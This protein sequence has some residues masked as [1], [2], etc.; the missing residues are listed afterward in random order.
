MK[1]TQKLHLAVFGCGF[2]AQYQTAAWQELSDQIEIIALCDR[3]LSRARSL[4]GKLGIGHYYDSPEKLLQD[5]SPHI[6]DIITDV[7]S[8]PSLAKLAADHGAHV[9]CQKPMAASLEKA[10]EMTRYLKGKKVKFYVHENFR[11]QAPIRLLKTYLQEGL[12]G[13]PFK[14]NIKFC[15]SF[16]VFENQPFLAELDQFIL[17][18]VGTHILDVTRFLFGEA[19]SLFCQTQRINPKIQGEDVANVFMRM[20]NAVDCYA[21][22]SYATIWEHERF[23]ETYIMI[24]GSKGSLYL[25]PKFTISITTDEGTRT[26]VVPIEPFS[27]AHVEYALIHSSIYACNANILSELTGNGVAETT[28]EDN[29]KTLQL[30][31]DAYE[32][33]KRKKVIHY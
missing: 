5:H 7:D 8:H 27:W 21:E 15:S 32:S 31:Y 3:D 4:A 17:T 10:V 19:E 16:P 1:R 14:A 23:P 2:W 12:I 33:A 24:E 20:Q 30:V 6:V 29:L 13:R 22:M 9:I 11:W 18:D 25:G 26:E 28:G